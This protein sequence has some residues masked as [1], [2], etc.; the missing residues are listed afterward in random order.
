MLVEVSPKGSHSSALPGDMCE[1]Q[2][3][4]EVS[5]NLKIRSKRHAVQVQAELLLGGSFV[6]LV[7]ALTGLIVT[8]WLN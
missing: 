5:E 3:V 1:H 7:G 6:K 2:V 8:V 4:T